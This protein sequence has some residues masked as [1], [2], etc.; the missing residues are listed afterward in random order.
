MSKDLKR[1]AEILLDAA[2]SAGADGADALAVHGASVSIDVLDGKLEHAERAEGTDIGL[3]VLVGQKQACISGSDLR[4]T[5]LT[6][7]AECAVAMA[8]EAPDD[9]YACQ[10][11]PG[12]FS[13]IRTADGLELADPAAAPTPKQLEED[14][15]SAE[16]AARA[17]KG[18]D[19]VQGTSAGYSES[20][21]YL[22]TSKGFH[23]GY[24][25]TSR[26]VSCVAI[27]GT[28]LQ[29]E[30]DYSGE[31][32]VYQADLP[33]AATIGTEAGERAVTR[34]GASKPP[35]GSY[36]VLFDERISATLIGH[37]ISA[38]NGTSIVRGA[39][40]LREAMGQR[41]LP[42][43]LSLIEDPSRKRI[44]GS[45]PFDGEGL[46]VKSRAIVELGILSSWVLDLSTARQLGL[47][48]TGNAARGTSA[49]PSPSAGN[50][51]LK[52]GTRSRADLISDMGTGLIVTSLIGS[53]INANTGDYSRGAS[54]FWV[55]NGKITRPVNECTIAGNLR[56]MLGTCLA[57]TD[58]R[59]HLSRR[60]PSLLVERMTIAGA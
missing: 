52:G 57:A 18:V 29:M 47:E 37:L 53:S 20:A 8:R 39:S 17:I 31:S 27:A 24:A 40:W 46:A 58:A 9:P 14:A 42:E 25:R 16:A 41:V 60:I 15:L 48:S 34:F 49:P 2:K 45:R 33:D 7:M 56:E 5:S 23:G 26:S 4:E 38:I 36:P 3:R 54:G 30:R 1:L 22:A 59:D 43:T 44:G 11:E 6:T 35:T 10:A 32:R 51:D 19:Q 13:K 28:G 21:I 12:E 55:E 50:I